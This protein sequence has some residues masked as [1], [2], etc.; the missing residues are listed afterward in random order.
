[1]ANT[2]KH[3]YQKWVNIATVFYLLFGLVWFVVALMG[4][5]FNALALGMMAIY[6]AQLYYRHLITNLIL[7]IVFLFLSIFMLLE[8]INSAVLEARA[9]HAVLAYQGL[10]ALFAI[11]L[12][13]AGI[14]VFSYIKMGIRD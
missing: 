4:G 8:S 9:H 6:G 12:F 13:M 5:R 2:N 7:G 10:I 14:L 11:S 1:M 3:P